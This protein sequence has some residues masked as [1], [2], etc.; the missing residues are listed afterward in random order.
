MVT[1]GVERE[2]VVLDSERLPV[3]SLKIVSFG[4]EEPGGSVVLTRHSHASIRPRAAASC[5]ILLPGNINREMPIS[6]PLL[7]PA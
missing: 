2:P 7:V 4:V 6:I 1:D 3:C 5:S